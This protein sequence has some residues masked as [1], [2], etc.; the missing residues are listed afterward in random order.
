MYRLRLREYALVDDG[1]RPLHKARRRLAHVRVEALDCYGVTTSHPDERER[2][3]EEQDRVDTDRS[4][5]A[6]ADL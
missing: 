6:A 4:A 1:R 5:C 3:Q 2:K